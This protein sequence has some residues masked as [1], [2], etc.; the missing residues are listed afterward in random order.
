M[1]SGEVISSLIEIEPDDWPNTVTRAES[2]PKAA[3]L[4]GVSQR[5]PHK[6]CCGQAEDLPVSSAY[7]PLAVGENRASG[8][9][10]VSDDW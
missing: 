1:D 2:P 10:S 7:G 4:R 6:Y 3:M 9:S 8:Q 5:G